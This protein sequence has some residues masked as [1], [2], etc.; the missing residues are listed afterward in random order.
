MRPQILVLGVALF[1]GHGGEPLPYRTGGAGSRPAPSSA[2]A[3]QMD[4]G[5]FLAAARGAAPVICSLAAAPLGDGWGYHGAPLDP[6]AAETALVAWALQPSLDERDLTLLEA[7]LR[8]ADAC[9]RVMSA[10]LLAS[11]EGD[12]ARILARALGDESAPT[13]RAAAEGLGYADQPIATSALIR[14]LE[15]DDDAGVRAVAAWAL[16]RTEAREAEAAL[17][18]ALRDPM[19]G[20]RLAA[21]E[22]LGELEMESSVDL[23]LPMLLDQDPRARAAT[24]RALGELN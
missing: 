11:A 10:R 9:V 22:A 20:V 13:R 21:I 24:A 1:I 17:G 12:G 7:G 14:R 6:D 5:R 2:A 3:A 8:D 23:L 18:A 19:P 15:D 16:G 4:A